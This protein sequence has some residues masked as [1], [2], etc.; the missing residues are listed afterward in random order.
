MN[1]HV[2][3]FARRRRPTQ[4]AEGLPRWRWTTAELEKMVDLGVLDPDER[5]ELIGGEIV[6]MSPKGRRHEIVR[7]ALEDWFRP[8]WPEGMK[9][10]AE[11]QFNLDEAVYTTPDLLVKP[12]VLLTPDLRGPDALLVIE[13][14]ASS[15]TKDTTTK[16]S[17]YAT[18]GVRE[19]WVIDADTLLTRVHLQP[20]AAG[21]GSVRD[22][23]GTEVITPLLA[24]ALAVRLAECGL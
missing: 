5:V 22:A 19:Y 4:A 18:F 12:S 15:W 24:P 21:Y 17:V 13:V 1:E 3:G 16:A 7:E 2:K 20:S 11:P 6:P 8:R 23:P 10:I 9:V 14:A